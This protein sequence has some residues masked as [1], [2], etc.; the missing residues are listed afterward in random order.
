M[1]FRYDA[2]ADRVELAT[3]MPRFP[4]DIGFSPDPAGGWC[5][6]I[7]LPHTARI[8]YLL[9]VWEGGQSRLILD[10]AN[11]ETATN[12]FGETSV[13]TGSG[14][15]PPRWLED[16]PE[17]GSVTE[18]R[19]SSRVLAHRRSHHIYHPAGHADSEALPLLVVHDGTDYRVHA[20]LLRALDSLIGS[21]AIQPLRAVLLD[22]RERH[23]E[24]VGSVAHA[25]HVLDEV[26]PHVARRVKVKAPFGI[27][28]ASLGAV[29]ALHVARHRPGVF[30]RLFLQ[31]GT[32]A[33]GPH[34]ELSPEMTASIREVTR[35]VLKDARLDGAW[36]YAGC[37]RYESLIDWN[38]SLM[39]SLA[40]QFMDVT[41]V[42]TWSGHDWGA[43]RDH[44][45]PGLRFLYGD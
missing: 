41:F 45:E 9:R 21:G 22:P 24:Y 44:F 27:M 7:P 30:E 12:P 14:Y 13:V 18:I 42:E 36:V 20:D 6:E 10:P 25:R 35:T 5:L 37:G 23:I 34:P 3:F 31:S 39:A 4:K 40:D 1:S 17:P 38:R 28:G 19:V 8:E 15:H 32:F 26:L 16:H 2:P 11:P 33:Q 29:A 43:W